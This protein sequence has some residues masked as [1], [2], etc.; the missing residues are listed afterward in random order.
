MTPAR[1]RVSIVVPA[2]NG[3][4]FIGEAIDSALAQSFT[5][6]E[7]VVVDDRSTDATVE[8]VRRRGDSR[9][10]IVV[11]EMNLGLG[12]NWNKALAEARGEFIKLLP[13]DDILSPDCIR[14]QVAAFDDPGNASVVL[15]CC[16]RNIV[17]A[18]GKVLM[19][20]S[21]KRRSGQLPGTVAVRESVRAGT[22]LIGEPGA[23]LLRASAVASAGVFDA[24]DLYLIDFDYWCRA[25][26]QGNIYIIPEALCAFRIS[27]QSTSARIAASQSRDFRNFVA[28]I[29]RDRRF[30][31]SPLDRASGRA[32]AFLNA[33]LRRGLYFR[34][35]RRFSSPG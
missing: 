6:F 19:K 34:L 29:N 21:F 11:N 4:T 1:P 3:E 31:L 20:R 22:N 14:R 35:M 17:D 9:L 27:A 25:L 30:G 23:V 13:Q 16:A 10:R 28:R 18:A 2:Y 32:R 12:A 7:L 24:V 5:D 33:L 15:V 8:I 26:L